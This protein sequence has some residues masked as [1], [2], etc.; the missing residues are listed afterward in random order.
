MEY[1]SLSIVYRIK[2]YSDEQLLKEYHTLNR[3]RDAFVDENGIF[4]P[5]PQS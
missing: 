3:K 5:F 4:D 2:G 1:Q